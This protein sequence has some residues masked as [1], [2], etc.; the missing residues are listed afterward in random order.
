MDT[1]FTQENI[2]KILDH[3][4]RKAVDGLGSINPSVSDL[5]K[6]YLEMNSDIETAT[7]LMQKSQITK[8]TTSGFVLGLG[9]AITLP[10]TIATI[11]ADMTNV[12]YIQL[13]MIACTA[14]MAGYDVYSDQIRTLIY[15]CL[16]DLS[17]N[18]IVKECGIK[19]G[20]KIA[21]ECIKKIPGKMLTK[22]NQKVGFRLMTKFGEKGIINLGKMVPI[23]GGVIG[24]GLNLVE[25]KAIA[26]RA[27]KNFTKQEINKILF[28]E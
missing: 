19:I 9:G 2:W 13:K 22:I 5:A 1:L 17:V 16:V 24:G 3:L 25:T 18:E 27:Y 10:V 20:S 6:D 11:S 14:Y 23:V 21:T 12:L 7:K 26:N 28:Y 8:C 4:Y 15:T